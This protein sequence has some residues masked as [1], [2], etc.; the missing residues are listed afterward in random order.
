MRHVRRP[1][2]TSLYRPRSLGYLRHKLVNNVF[3]SS[4]VFRELSK[5]PVPEGGLM[6][7][8]PLSYAPPPP[9]PV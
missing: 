3:K 5:L 6:L 4:P 8:S 1:H 9:K 7:A 2:K